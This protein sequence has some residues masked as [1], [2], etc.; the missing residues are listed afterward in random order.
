MPIGKPAKVLVEMVKDVIFDRPP[1]VAG[2][3]G[4]A[5]AVVVVVVVVVATTAVV[6]VVVVAGHGKVS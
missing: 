2:I 3:A 6:V 5:A 4:I 1:V